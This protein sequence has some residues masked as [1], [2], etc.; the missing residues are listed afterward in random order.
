MEIQELLEREEKHCYR[1]WV[2]DLLLGVLARSAEAA[3]RQG[4]WLPL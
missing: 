1:G 4:A 3:G 2:G